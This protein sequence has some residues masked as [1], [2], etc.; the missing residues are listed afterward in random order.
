M[1]SVNVSIAELFEILMAAALRRKRLIL[2]P[3]LIFSAL[4]ILAVLSWPRQYQAHA[5]LMLQEGQSADPLSGGNG[6]SRQGRL[7]A[8]EIDTLLK[9]DRVLAGAISDMN[10]GKAPLS[11]GDVEGAIRSLRKQIGV[12]VV[13]NEFIDIEFKQS[14]R[15]GIGERLSI[16]LTRFFEHLLTREYAMKTAREFALEQRRR[17]VVSTDAAIEDW[18]ARVKS[19]RA[20][21]QV[22]D[23]KAPASKS[24][25]SKA[26]VSVDPKL[27]ELKK[28]H[29]EL[30]QKVLASA[31]T[32]LPGA[33]LA[34]MDQ[35][36]H[37]ELRVATSRAQAGQLQGGQLQA[38]QLQAGQFEGM[39]DRTG[40]LKALAADIDGYRALGLDLAK[41]RMANA[42]TS[43]QSL[44]QSLAGAKDDTAKT[45]YSGLYSEWEGLAA[46]HVEALEQ[47]DNHVKRAKKSSGPSM[48]PFGLV[49]PE[50]IRIIDEPRDPAL[51]AT[52]LLKIVVAC[53]AAGVGLGLGL[54]A[55]AEQ[56]DDRIYDSR[57]LSK[58][59]GV[60]AVFKIPVIETAL[61]RDTDADGGGT[62][63]P[64]RG[65]LMVVSGA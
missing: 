60:D 45:L 8:E 59:A 33:N 54:A 35:V 26:D 56:F 40:A 58:L 42:Q 23:A 21:G 7:K 17:D 50:S 16:I 52:S 37:D 10:L 30:E 43:A 36:I 9:S 20:S 44:L 19:G 13:G 27:A 41:Q 18:M 34:S 4:S 3:I 48:T 12:S 53:L 24:S 11:Q 51:P 57:T 25:D 55:L 6:Q 1:F 39:P 46:R 62:R 65:H 61:Q 49:A 14:E 63:A 22:A 31:N 47:F 64:Q 38:G 15:D 5:L 28:R 29:L 32:L 2:M